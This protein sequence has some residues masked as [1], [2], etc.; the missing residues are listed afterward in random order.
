MLIL[1]RKVG[2]VILIGDGIRVVVLACDRGGVRLGIEAPNDVTILRG[3]IVNDVATENQRAGKT[4]ASG[5]QDWLQVI[6][7]PPPDAPSASEDEAPRRRAG[8]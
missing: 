3:E 4:A 7:G 5:G 8:E 1:G 6:G 2:D